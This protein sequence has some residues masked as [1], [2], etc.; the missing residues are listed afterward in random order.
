MFGTTDRKHPGVKYLLNCGDIFLGGDILLLDNTKEPYPQFN[1][2]PKETRA[3][4]SKKGWKTIAGF[5]TRNVPHRGHEY[6]HRS[7]LKLVDGLFIHPVMGIKKPGDFKDDCIVASYQTI[8]NK[9]YPKNRVTFAILPYQMRYAGPKEA[10][11]HA[12]IRKNFGCTHFIVGRD[13]AGVGNY[14]GP[15]DAK[16]IFEKIASPE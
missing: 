12:I 5:Q 15:Y 16:K 2:T 1:L 4:F 11:L 6:L 9:Y 3:L 13:H 8:I 10:V 7:V 14:Y